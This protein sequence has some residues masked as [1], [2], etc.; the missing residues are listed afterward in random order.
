[1]DFQ[2]GAL[3]STYMTTVAPK[4]DAKSTHFTHQIP[5]VTS[6]LDQ[7]EIDDGMVLD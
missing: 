2:V 6:S 4:N 7:H 3:Y 1:M 5:K